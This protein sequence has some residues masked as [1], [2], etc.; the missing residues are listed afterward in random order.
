M[1]TKKIT[2]TNN[3]HGTEVTVYGKRS[4]NNWI[5]D[6]SKAQVTKITKALCGMAECSCG[7]TRESVWDLYNNDDGSGFL[8][9][10]EEEYNE[11]WEG[12]TGGKYV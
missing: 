7:I 1:K 9:S 5:W 3:F 2:L 11:Q 4:Y 10:W 6:L 12:I 8:R